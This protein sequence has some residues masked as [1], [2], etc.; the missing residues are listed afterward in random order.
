MTQTSFG[1]LVQTAV[2]LEVVALCC[3][4]DQLDPSK[5]SKAVPPLV[6]AEPTAN[7]LSDALPATASNPQ[8]LPEQLLRLIVVAV[9]FAPL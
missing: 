5:R 4:A 2:R 8:L 6:V 9:Q 1:P 3:T 7:T